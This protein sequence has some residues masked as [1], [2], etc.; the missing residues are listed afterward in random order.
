M[1]TWKIA[2]ALAMA[3]AVVAGAGLPAQAGEFGILGIGR[4][5]T[6][7]WDTGMYSG[8]G[9]STP[10]IGS[11][12]AGDNVAAACRIP[13]SNGQLMTLG[14]DRPGHAGVQWSN[15]AGYIWNN[16]LQGSTESLLTCT[17][18]QTY[19][20]VRDT[21]L[22]SAPG[23]STPRVGTVWAGEWFHAICKIPDSNGMRM[24]LGVAVSGRA[25]VQVAKTVG[26]IWDLDVYEST[27]SVTDCGSS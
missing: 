22:Y 24:V 8:P 23:L 4:Q 6:P 2:A 11:A 17:E 13:D 20:A 18:F 21:G 14:I 19:H 25:G 26:Y 3:T 16:D 9:L 5:V 12:W 27:N 1:K 7:K 15:T 10:R